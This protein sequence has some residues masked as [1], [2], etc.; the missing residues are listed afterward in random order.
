VL[1]ILAGVALTPLARLARAA[2]HA[3]GEEKK[4]PSSGSLPEQTVAALG[5]SG[6]VYV[7]PLK[8]DGSE[9]TCHGEVWFGWIDGAV[10]LI[11]G[12]ER[13]KSR[14]LGKDLD[15]ARIWVGDHG[16]WKGLVTKSE[17][18][19]KAPHFDA[20]AAAVK[21]EALLERLL[22]I[23]DVKYPEEIGAWRD[24]MRSGFHDGSRVLIRY[25]PV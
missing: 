18:F 20:R 2:G 17:G 24:K 21:D 8:S 22:A 13:W 19:R 14:A 10:V 11:T 6:L 3:A 7:S 4:A 5:T 15:G 12:A 9:S 23:Y 16:R 1:G 25:M